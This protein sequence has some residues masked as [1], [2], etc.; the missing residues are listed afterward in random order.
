MRLR[1]EWKNKINQLYEDV[2]LRRKMGLQG[3]EFVE[4]NYDWSK[5]TQK[6]ENSL[7]NICEV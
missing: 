7:V 6:M 3:R 4:Q 1:D 2:G 5:I